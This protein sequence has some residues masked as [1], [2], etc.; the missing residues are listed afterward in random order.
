MTTATIQDGGPPFHQ[1]ELLRWRGYDDRQKQWNVREVSYAGLDKHDPSFAL[2]E[3]GMRSNGVREVFRVPLT[4]LARP[5]PKPIDPRFAPPPITPPPPPPTAITVPD[6]P[7]LRGALRHA[8]DRRSE[9]QK[10]VDAAAQL[11]SRA[12]STLAAA[13]SEL[14][15]IALYEK[16]RERELENAIR[17]GASPPADEET[18]DRGKAQRQVDAAEAVVEK[19]REEFR[20][21]RG[22]GANANSAIIDAAR[23]VTAALFRAEAQRLVDEITG[24]KLGI[25]P[26]AAVRF[27]GEHLK[28]AE[29]GARWKDLHKR[30]VDGD[31]DADLSTKSVAV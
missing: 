25:W 6:I 26:E 28:H 7:V 16:D 1:N 8:I 15:R 13:R 11:V 19:L 29:Q 31:A 5:L 24:A 20:D 3:W 4:E 9:L 17:N 23:A 22:A 27:V 18:A 12:E 2:V 21:A 10:A 30:L 14:A